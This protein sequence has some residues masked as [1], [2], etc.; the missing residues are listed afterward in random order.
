MYHMRKSILVLLLTLALL[1]VGCG[2]PVQAPEAPTAETEAA[3]V[4][5]TQPAETAQPEYA[6]LS[7]TTSTKDASVFDAGGSVVGD[8]HFECVVF[9]GEAEGLH[10]INAYLAQEAENRLHNEDAERFRSYVNE[11][12][13]NS[14][15]DLVAQPFF[16]TFEVQSVFNDD[17]YISITMNSSWFAGGVSNIDTIGYNFLIETGELIG[18]EGLFGGDAAAAH[19][20]VVQASLEMIQGSDAFWPDAEDIIRDFVVEPTMFCFDEDTIYVSYPTYVLSYGGA[21]PQTVAFPR[22]TA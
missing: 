12:L 15:Q 14:A 10:R 22:P 17:K 20:A 8:L 3:A 19:D 5:P 11:A 1:L 7:Y 13:T 16:D 18:I 4:T 21:G 9:D 2:K 6:P